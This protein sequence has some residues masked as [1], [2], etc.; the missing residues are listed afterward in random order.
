M[1][2]RIGDVNEQVQGLAKSSRYL[3]MFIV[4]NTVVTQPIFS[5]ST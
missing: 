2:S 5:L 3:G 4:V 1:Q